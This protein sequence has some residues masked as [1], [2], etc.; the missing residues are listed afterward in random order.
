MDLSKLLPDCLTNHLLAPHT[1]MKVGG[2]ADFFYIANT[3]EK[4]QNVIKIARKQ[5]IDYLVLGNGSNV[6][7]SDSG[8]RGLVIKNQAANLVIGNNE[9]IADSGIELSV[10]IRKLAEKNLGN[11]E[12]L[13]GIPGTLGGA[14]FG[15]AGAFG[16]SI[17]DITNSV[18]ILD[19]EN[20]IHSLSKTEM[21]FAYRTSILKKYFQNQTENH[22][23]ILS[24]NLKVISQK[25]EMILRIIDNYLRIR[26]TKQPKYFSC[27]SFFK[28]LDLKNFPDLPRQADL[29]TVEDK[30][31]AGILLERS[32]AKTIHVGGASVYSGHANWL[33]NKNRKARA[34]DIKKLADDL[35][36]KV[37]TK[38]GVEL[39]EEINYIGDFK[40]PPKSFLQKIFN[41]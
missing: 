29:A 41:K 8:F 24:V 20:K 11:L 1:T 4:L 39:E 15:N 32:G 26:K 14:V 38:F 30:I 31:P 7:I 13:A 9:A 17:A 23:V 6:I 21:G 28:N 5:K 22:P 16:K 27:G 34:F 12:F 36:Q 2:C 35:K 19:Q 40:T 33:I 25:K 18:L 3:L 10:L 37:R